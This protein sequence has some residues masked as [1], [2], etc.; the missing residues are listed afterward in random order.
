VFQGPLHVEI[1]R[2]QCSLQTPACSRGCRPQRRHLRISP[3]VCQA[4]D[5]GDITLEDDWRAFRARKIRQEQQ[6]ELN[7]DCHK[8]CVGAFGVDV[9]STS[10][11][12]SGPDVAA[13]VSPQRMWAGPLAA[14]IVS[15]CGSRTPTWRRR[16]C[17]RSPP[18]RSRQGRCW[19]RRRARPSAT[20]DTSSSWCW[21]WNTP[22]PAR[23]ASSSTGRRWRWSMTSWAGG[24]RWL[25]GSSPRANLFCALHRPCHQPNHPIGVLVSFPT[26]VVARRGRHIIDVRVRLRTGVPGRHLPAKCSTPPHAHLTK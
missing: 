12:S 5:D 9:A 19:S 14:P 6:R 26:Q 15:C 7:G 21:C 11:Y 2:S 20:R 10:R 23:Q 17:G 25:P 4:S 1:K 8:P 24:A 22:A 18:T 13:V 16:A 3:C